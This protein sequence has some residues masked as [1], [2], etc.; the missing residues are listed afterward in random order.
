MKT[1]RNT[2]VPTVSVSACPICKSPDGPLLHSASRDRWFGAPGSWA[3]RQCSRCDGLWLDPRPTAAALPLVYANY[4]THEDATGARRGHDSAWRRLRAHLPWHAAD[5]RG[6]VG[7]LDRVPPGRVL[8]VGCGNGARLSPLSRAGWSP[9]GLDLD[10]SAVA[11]ARRAFD[12]DVRVGTIHDIDEAASFDAI[13]MFHVLEHMDDPLPALIRAR[14]LLRPGGVLSIATPNAMS[15][16]HRLYRHQWRGLEPPRHLQVF[17]P[18]GLRKV[19]GEAGFDRPTIFT[20]PRNA[21]PLSCASENSFGTT[22]ALVRAALSIKGE[23]LQALEWI[24]LQWSPHCGEELVAIA[25]T[26]RSR[27][28]ST[29]GIEPENR[30]F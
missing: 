4:Y 12:G 30:C 3:F 16:L 8:D 10:R 19:L 27:V 11:V 24:R 7:Y 28:G 9:V 26:H 29:G 21:G 23:L 20:T 25:A 13:L 17:A 18:P 14:E 6:A 22:S 15:W 1:N 2:V 5:R